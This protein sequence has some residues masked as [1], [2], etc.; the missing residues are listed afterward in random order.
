VF[1]LPPSEE[2]LPIQQIYR[3]LA[4]NERRNQQIIEDVVA[5]VRE[6]RSPILL[7]ERTSHADCFAAALEGRVQ[8]IV[9]LKGGQGIKQRR[10]V[11]AQIA[12]ISTGI[13][14]VLIATGRYIGEGF[15]DT[16]L[17][18]LFLTLPVSWSGTL[19]Q[20]VGRRHRLHAGKTEARVC[21]YVDEAVPMLSEMYRKRIRGYSAVGYRITDGLRRGTPPKGNETTSA[22]CLP[23]P[24]ICRKSGEAGN[25]LAKP[26]GNAAGTH[27]SL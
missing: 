4:E 14:R 23:P 25:L 9:S 26:S 17:D 15:D 11:A 8:N 18:T 22:P 12:E 7:T 21:D 10:K 24:Q 6:G 20:D 5:A 13:D 1:Q 27:V 3:L 16:R 19:Q 2:P